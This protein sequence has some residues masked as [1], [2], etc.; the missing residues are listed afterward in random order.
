MEIN[1]IY[2]GNCLEVLKKFDDDIFDLGIT[3]P[4]Y[5]KLQAGGGKKSI[6]GPIVYDNFDDTLPEDEY[7]KQ[8]IDI[9]NELYRT[10]IPG[11]SFFYNH[12]VRHI[13]N[14]TINPIEW[15]IKTDWNIKQEIIWDRISALNIRGYHFW[16]YDERIYWLYKPT[17][18]N[19]MWGPLESKHANLSSIWRVIPDRNNDHPAPFPL[20]L[21]VRVMSSIFKDSKYKLVIDPYMGSGTTGVACKFLSQHYVGIDISKKYI[22]EANSRIDNYEKEHKIFRKEVD[23]Y[24]VVGKTWKERKRK[25]L[26]DIEDK[27]FIENKLKEWGGKD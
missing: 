14:N 21:P 20:E 8:Q 6:F 5:N 17:K 22:D 24:K 13:K 1:K 11:G 2:Q 10:T 18:D 16:Q 19:K 9:L 27:E 7:Q 3:S 26:K 12:K 15:L 25:E 4:P 23:S